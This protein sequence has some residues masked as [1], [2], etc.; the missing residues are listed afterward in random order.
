M[1]SY[2]GR[3]TISMLCRTRR[4][5]S[6]SPSTNILRAPQTRL[7]SRSPYPSGPYGRKQYQRLSRSQLVKY[8]YQNSLVFRYG[9]RAVGTGSAGFVVY[10][11]ET[12][13]VSGR[14]RFNWVT[15]EHEEEMGNQQYQQIL[16]EFRGQI[17]PS[18]HP[19]VRMVHRVLNRLIP[20]SGLETENWEVHVIDDKSQVNAFV[21]P[22]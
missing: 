2:L 14:L 4:P 13:P 3:S 5:L 22:G 19:H 9:V 16:Q 11:L 12:V 8:L 17:L 6:A 18:W 10:N 15:P 1:A 20:A 7:Q 21:I